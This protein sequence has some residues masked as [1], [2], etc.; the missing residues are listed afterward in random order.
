MLL[1]NS[2]FQRVPTRWR[3]LRRDERTAAPRAPAASTST[4]CFRGLGRFVTA[5]PAVSSLEATPATS[6]AA[7]YKSCFS[8]VLRTR[9]RRARPLRLRWLCYRCPSRHC[10]SHRSRPRF[11]VDRG[12]FSDQRYVPSSLRKGPF[13]T[14]RSRGGNAH[15]ALSVL[16][17]TYAH[18]TAGDVHRRDR[19]RGD[20]RARRES[21]RTVWGACAER[22]LLFHIAGR[23]TIRLGATYRSQYVQLHQ[24]RS[25]RASV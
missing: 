14:P 11:P 25:L 2:D 16:W 4:T 24:M 6:L 5:Q 9:G 8:G 20:A 17:S 22:A 7:I 23:P 3:W 10:Y 21:L 19:R 12:S 1:G 13:V 15:P 18:D